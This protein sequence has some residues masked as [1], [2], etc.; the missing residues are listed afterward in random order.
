[1]EHVHPE[2]SATK[3]F[4]RAADGFNE[5]PELADWSIEGIKEFD[6]DERVL[7]VIAHDATL[8][9][10][11]DFFPKPANGWREKGWRKAGHWRF[12]GDFVQGLKDIN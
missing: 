12:L 5:C 9:P 11:I 3:P 2:K 10:V 1:M 8:L 4:Y 6:A 7:S